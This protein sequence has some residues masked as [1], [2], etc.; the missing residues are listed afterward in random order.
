MKAV[1]YGL[2]DTGKKRESN[3]DSLLVDQNLGLFIACDGVSGQAAGGTASQLAARFVKQVISENRAIVDRAIKDPS[4]SNRAA[5]VKLMEQAIEFAGKEIFLAANADTTKK[6]MSTTIEIF[7][8]LGSYAILGHVGDSRIYLMRKGNI[9]QLTEDHSVI[10][11]LMK[12]GKM[13]PEQAK[14]SPYAHVITRAVGAYEFVQADTLQVELVSGDLFL[15]CT[16]G[17]TDLLPE[18]E[19]LGFT[20][21]VEDP[22]RI[23]KELVEAANAAGGKDNITAVVVQVT[24]P[25]LK[26]TTVNVIRKMEMVGKIQLFRYLSYQELTKV[27]SIGTIQ[28]LKRGVTIYDEG[29]ASHEMF[30]LLAGEVE[31]KKGGRLIAT[32]APGESLG[33]MGIIDQSPRSASVSTV[34][35]STVMSISREKLFEL[36]R[37]HPDLAVKFFWALCSELNR[38]LRATTEKLVDQRDTDPM[39]SDLPFSTHPGV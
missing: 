13:T 22:S 21:S 24:G 18:A 5:A 17:L 9:H 8:N 28:E 10:S 32:R 25:A 3:D 2:T 34:V 26:D 23:P 19:L 30:I 36:L 4:A 6:G 39:L 33:E 16:D 20:S 35:P 38:R 11:E 15:L 27:L 1:G 12:S 7:L 37:G 14:K 29:E 31:V